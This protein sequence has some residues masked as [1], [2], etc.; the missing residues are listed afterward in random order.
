MAAALGPSVGLRGQS[1]PPTPLRLLSAQG[2]RPLPSLVVN[3]N[4]F[5]ALDE[6]IL[7]FPIVVRDDQSTHS[8]TVTWKGKTAVLNPDQSLASVGGRLISLPSTPIKI[9]GKW[10]VPID[11]IGRVLVP[12]ADGPLEFRR[13]SRLVIAG[14]VRLPRV[15]IRHELPGP[16]ARVTF[17]ISPATPHSIVQEATRLVVRFDADALDTSIGPAP[18]QSVVTAIHPTETGTGIALDLGPRF[19]SFRATDMPGDASIMHLVVEVFPTLES[20]AG[21]ASPIAPPEQPPLPTPGTATHVIV[22]DPGHGGTD[23]G[24]H[25]AKGLLEKD[26]TLALA[27]RL[28]VAIE[29]RIGARVLLTRDDDRIVSPDDRAA[30]ANNNKG[31]IFVS[32]HVAGSP[33]TTLSGASVFS[34]AADSAP[35]A[36]AGSPAAETVSMPVFGGTSREI[37]LTPWEHAQASHV[38]DSMD[39][40]QRMEA[41]LRSVVPLSP[42]PRQ[43]APLRVLVGANMPAV[44]VE[45]GFLSNPVQARQLA[46]DQFQNDIVQALVDGIVQFRDGRAP[47]GPRPSGPGGTR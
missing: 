37:A 24:V 26:V 36:P 21:P 1:P 10:F 29:S 33:Q 2:S 27:R 44:L 6:L 9:G 5:I 34:L 25:G 28:K 11:F 46:S 14:T 17:D 40:A 41:T 16:Q 38:N 39:L 18:A 19:G 32:L 30:L 42:R 15:V 22:I 47:Q 12:I 43:Q 13:A 35:P 20:S 7:V 45:M 4:E 8:I 23:E 31:D 3:D